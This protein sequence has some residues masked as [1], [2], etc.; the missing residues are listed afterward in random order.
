MLIQHVENEIR[1]EIEEEVG[2]CFNELT[3]SLEKE[4]YTVDAIYNGFEVQLIQKKFIIDVLGQITLTKSKE[5]ST[6]E[7]LR[8]LHSTR[9]Y[10]LITVVNDVVNKEAEYCNFGLVSYML[11]HPNFY[12]DKFTTTVDST[13]IYTVEHKRS[14]EWFRFAIRGCVIPPGV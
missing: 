4:G 8:I 7:N 9:L 1:I 2:L 12:I 10:D 13:K 5:V 11:L 14:N 3:S 6:L